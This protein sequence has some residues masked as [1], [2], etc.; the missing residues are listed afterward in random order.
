MLIGGNMLVKF[1]HHSCFTIELEDNFLVF[2]YFGKGNL[3]LP[4]DKKVY[5]ISS[6]RHADHFD[7]VIFDYDAKCYILSDDIEVDSSFPKNIRLVKP[8]DEIELD[9]LKL[10]FEESTDEG[11]LLSLEVEKRH[12]LFAGDHN[13]WVWDR[14]SKEEHE[15]MEIWFKGEVD[16]FKKENFDLVM[17]PVDPRMKDAY[18]LAGDYYIKTLRPKHFFPMHMWGEF[19][20]SEKFKNKLQSD[21]DFCQIHVIKNDGQEFEI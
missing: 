10:H 15:R 7:R 16:K 2:D 5:F 6:H 17:A 3:R 14:Y 21:Y 11:V 20:I 9:D 8:Q 12:I 1:I 19:S 4:R 18:W 13:W